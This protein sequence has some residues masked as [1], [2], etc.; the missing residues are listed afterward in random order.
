MVACCRNASLDAD[1]SPPGPCVYCDTVVCE[2]CES[3]LPT[4]DTFAVF[5]VPGDKAPGRLC[6]ACL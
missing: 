5:W 4:R 1:S 6:E 2:G 3:Y